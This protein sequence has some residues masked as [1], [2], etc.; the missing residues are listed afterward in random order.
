MNYGTKDEIKNSDNPYL[1]QF[2]NGLTT[3]PI[4]V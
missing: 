4:E 1:Q 2:V 3:G